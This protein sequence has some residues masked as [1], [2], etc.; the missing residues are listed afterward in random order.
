M[1]LGCSSIGVLLIHHFTQIKACSRLAFEIQFEP[2]VLIKFDDDGCNL[3]EYFGKR[4]II[5]LVSIQKSKL[6]QRSALCTQQLHHR[7]A[8]PAI[9]DEKINTNKHAMFSEVHE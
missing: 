1:Y 5:Q 4:T 7:F 2:H 9:N 3:L 6:I 8:M